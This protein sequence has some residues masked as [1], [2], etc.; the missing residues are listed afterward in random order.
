MTAAWF[1]MKVL[2]ATVAVPDR[3]ELEA[4]AVHETVAEPLPFPL[5]VLTPIHEPFP[6]AVHAPV[7]PEGT[8]VIVTSCDPAE[9]VGLAEEGDTEKLVQA[10]V[11]APGYAYWAH[12]RSVELTALQQDAYIRAFESLA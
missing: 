2:P 1:T 11:V 5:P 4:F 6:V 9:A 10:G 8:P 12:V 3:E 7:H